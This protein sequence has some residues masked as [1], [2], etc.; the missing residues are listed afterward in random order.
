MDYRGWCPIQENKHF[1]ANMS[2][3]PQMK[4]GFMEEKHGYEIQNV[5]I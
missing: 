4:F 5:A 1:G 2:H 3:L